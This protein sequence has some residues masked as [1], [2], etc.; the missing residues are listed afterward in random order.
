MYSK[1]E[2]PRQMGGED[3]LLRSSDFHT[4]L[5]THVSASQIQTRMH[6]CMCTHADFSVMPEVCE[7]CLPYYVC[8][9]VFI[10]KGVSILLNLARASCSVLSQNLVSMIMA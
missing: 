6:A 8:G 9:S 2:C 10:P 7:R 1:Q 4:H 5:D 3:Q